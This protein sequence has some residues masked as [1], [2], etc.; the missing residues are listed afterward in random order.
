MTPRPH[1][2]APAL[3]LALL[4]G[5]GPAPW[6]GPTLTRPRDQLTVDQL[7][8]EALPEL[9]DMS[10]LARPDWADGDGEPMVATLSLAATDLVMDFPATRDLYAGEERFPA[11]ELE[12]VVDGGRLLPRRTGLVRTDEDSAWDVLLGEGAAWREAEDGAWSRASLPVDLVDRY[13]N[14]VRNCVATFVYRDD[15]V[16][17]TYVQCSQETADADD[18]QL[19][20]LQA[21][22]PTERAA[23]EWDADAVVTEHT[24]IRDGRLPVRPLSEWD[25]N[26]DLAAVFDKRLIT[27]AST[28]VGAVYADGTLWV[29]PAN[30][31][32]GPHPYPSEQR[33]GVYSVTKTL[34][35]ALAVFHFAERYGAEIVDLPVTGLVPELA[36][37]EAWEGVTL[38]DAL[39]MA[40]GTRGGESADLLFEPLVLAGSRAEALANIAALGDAEAGPGEAF[41]YATTNTFVVSCALQGLVEQREGPGVRYWELLRDDVL[42]PIGAA[43]LDVL[44]TREDPAERIPY[45]GFGARTRLDHAAKIAVLM[46]NEGEHAGQQ[47]LHRGLLREAL[48]RTDWEGLAI[49]GQ[50]RYRHGFW[51]RTV[52]TGSCDAQVAYMQGHGANH[53]LLLPSGAIVFRFMDEQDE[54]IVPLVR[55]AERVLSSC[56]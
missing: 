5:C 46:A 34:V 6:D 8:G 29:H 27:R 14:Q 30:T 23:A 41:G 52:R 2:R 1:L 43:G 31:R 47:L 33:H 38:G 40:T 12:L 18:E 36:G 13:F 25:A 45:L 4:S 53:V 32:H 42:A 55:G 50:H 15:A 39:D 16:S 48:G 11:L 3:A 26:G 35:G 51:S 24:R 54:N 22:V 7:H 44:L 21:L 37:A 17:P 20:N 28:S 9:L 49:D 56:D 19:G 10:F